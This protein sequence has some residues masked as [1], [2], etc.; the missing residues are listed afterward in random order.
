K[1]AYGMANLETDTPVKTGSI[2]HIAS[3]TKQFT[4]A[5]IMMLVEEGKVRLDDSIAAYINPMPESWAKITVRHLLTHTSGI[6]PGAIIRVDD[7][8]K[9]TTRAG[10]PLLDI[11]AKRALEVIAQAPLLFPAGERMLYC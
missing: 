9:L 3:V 7:Q 10:T 1:K 2:F 5:A 6:M 4:A 11:T 8:G